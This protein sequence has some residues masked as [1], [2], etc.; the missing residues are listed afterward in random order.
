MQAFF[1]F[2]R[3]KID[4]SNWLIIFSTLP[5][6]LQKEEEAII[7]SPKTIIYIDGCAYKYQKKG[8]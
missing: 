7:L 4:W 5:Y 1:E 3:R 6:T 8:E 2:L